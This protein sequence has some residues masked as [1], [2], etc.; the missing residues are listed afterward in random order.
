[1][2]CAALYSRVSTSDQ[3]IANQQLALRAHAR[4]RGWDAMEY[5][6][7]ISGAKNK[8]PGLDALLAAVRRR[9][10][11]AVVVVRLDRL[12]RS[13]HHLLALSRE[14]EELGVALVVTEQA[15]DTT[16]SV[17]RLMFAM[18]GAIAAFERDLIRERVQ[19]GLRR[20]RQQGTRS[21]KAI[22]RPRVLI[23]VKR[24]RQLLASGSTRQAAKA[25]GVPRSTLARAMGGPKPSPEAPR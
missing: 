13:I 21:G 8:R 25:L 20:A 15:I 1:M 7:V 22:G 6:D 17:G 4:A 11:D 18:L 14:L 19:A 24:A 16:T 9:Q 10:V 2:I 5:S 12:A 23:D 3:T